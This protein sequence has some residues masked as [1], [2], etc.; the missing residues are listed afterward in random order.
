M[1]GQH[2]GNYGGFGTTNRFAAARFLGINIGKEWKMTEEYLI[3]KTKAEI[4]AIGKKFKIFADPKAKAY[5]MK[6]FKGRDVDKLK[7]GE[8]VDLI[9]KSGVELTGKV[10]AEILKEAR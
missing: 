2:V 6:K 3:K 5:L 4:M 7:K 10:P 1:E 9:M 8:L